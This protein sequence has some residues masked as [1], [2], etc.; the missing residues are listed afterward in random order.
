[1]HLSWLHQLSSKYGK[2][3]TSLLWLEVYLQMRLESL[4]VIFD[5]WIL[6]NLVGEER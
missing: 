2:N 6:Q 3:I 1:L 4:S 5:N